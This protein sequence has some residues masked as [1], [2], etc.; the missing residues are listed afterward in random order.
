MTG[1]PTKTCCICGE[2]L[3]LTEFYVSACRGRS[4]PSSRCRACDT[5]YART[6]RNKKGTQIPLRQAKNIGAYLGV[7]IAERL[8]GN[9]FKTTIRMPYG[10]PGYD[11]ICG[12]GFKV[13]VKASCRRHKKNCPDRWHFNI[14]KNKSADYFACFAMDN[15]QGLNPEHFWLIPAKDINHRSTV[16]IFENLIPDWKKY[17]CPIENVLSACAALKGVP[18]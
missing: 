18:A 10:N 12:R 11:F 13:D 16:Q 1:A 3:P 7:H 17:E 14:K 4:Y 15:R 5:E 2:S 8:L 9:I 6:R